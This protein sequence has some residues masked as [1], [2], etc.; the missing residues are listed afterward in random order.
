[1]NPSR[2]RFL[3]SVAAA[4]G[5]AAVAPA[6]LQAAPQSSAATQ[7][8]ERVAYLAEPFPLAHVRLLDG[9]FLA[10]AQVN[11]AYLQSLPGERLVHMFRITAGLPSSAEP[12]GGWEAPQTELR[13]HFTGHYLSSCGLRHAMLGSDAVKQQGDAIVAELAV[14]QKANRN[15]YIS[16]FPESF[17]DRL[18][19]D[20]QVWAPF[21]TLHKIMAGCLDMFTLCGNRQALEVAAGLGDWTGHWLKGMGDDQLQRVLRTEF[22]GMSESLWNLAA[23]TGERGYAAGARRFEKT[24]FLDPL[25]A[26]RDAL[27]GLH[28]NTHIPQVIAAARRHEL[29][30]DPRYRE[31]SHYFWHEVVGE[32]S[33]APGGTSDGETWNTPPGQ[34]GKALSRYSQ[35]CCCGYNML[36]LT[37][38]LYTWSADPR[39]FDYYERT[40]WNSR[41]G[42]QH[43]GDGGKM[44]YFPLQTGWWKYF[45]SRTN[46]FWCCDGTGAE[47]FSKFADSIYFRGPSALFVN[48]FIPSE[49]RWPEQGLTVRQETRFPAAGGTTLR[50]TAGRA[51][52]LA[53]NLRIPSWTAAGGSVA[54]NGRRLEAFANPGSY[55]TLD[56]TWQTGDVVELTLPMALR[57][58][59]LQGDP[60]QQAPM[61]GPLV[62]A[63][64]LGG[65]GL[66]TAMQYDPDTA[67]AGAV[68]GGTQVAPRGRAQGTAEVSLPY[69]E[70]PEAAH[71]VKPAGELQFAAAGTELVPLH[72]ILGERYA[73]YW[74]VHRGPRGGA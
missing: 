21:Y 56:R 58:E 71:W 32:R 40:L 72:Q 65:D 74:Q 68:N 46:S 50:F 64:R 1:M 26:H 41:L 24:S 25:A 17:F 45:S 3:G 16:A 12:L 22:G 69:G 60:T 52:R 5:A 36:K 33:Y 34:L 70:E 54:V 67:P 19:N 53:V 28:V 47:E 27:Q 37:R 73:V 23:L 43:P 11:D 48:L 9:P 51:V 35:E 59:P 66:T 4:A 15:G 49:L 14:C 30:G 63:A 13:G 55:L 2:R 38:H 7:M 6:A 18:A 20:K 61:Y 57:A 42:T 8:P 44:Y 39:Y 62:L 10:A 31:I 29:T